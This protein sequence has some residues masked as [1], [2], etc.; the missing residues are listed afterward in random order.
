MQKAGLGLQMI[1]WENG[2]EVYILGNRLS[3]IS[4]LSKARHISDSFWHSK[5][6]ALC[7][8]CIKQPVADL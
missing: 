2:F 6:H 5:I 8:C 7:V 3:A 1:I 4:L